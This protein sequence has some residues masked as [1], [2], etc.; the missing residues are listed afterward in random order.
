MGDQILDDDID[1]EGEDQLPIVPGIGR[2]PQANVLALRRYLL[3][4]NAMLLIS[5]LFAAVYT[6]GFYNFIIFGENYESISEFSPSSSGMHDLEAG[7]EG[8]SWRT[9]VLFALVIGT[10]ALGTAI[11]YHRRLASSE[12][13]LTTYM[14]LLAVL[15]LWITY[16]L[17]DRGYLGTSGVTEDDDRIVFGEPISTSSSGGGGIGDE[18]SVNW[19]IVPNGDFVDSARNTDSE[20]AASLMEQC[21]WA[22]RQVQQFDAPPDAGGEESHLG[23]AHTGSSVHD[24]ALSCVIG[25]MSVLFATWLLMTAALAL[26]HLIGARRPQ[27]I[28]PTPRRS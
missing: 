13:C 28:P 25:S 2:F 5:V 27:L 4:G 9:N 24:L 1:L 26:L 8:L 11:G 17:D 22:P 6:T 15:T 10:A 3:W 7:S 14:L 12:I 23:E 21:R 16:E 20:A 19:G 18:A